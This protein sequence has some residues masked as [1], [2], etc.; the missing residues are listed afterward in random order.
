MLGCTSTTIQKRTQAHV[1]A[2]GLT[3]TTA[4]WGLILCLLQAMGHSAEVIIVP[5]LVTVAN[6]ELP[7]A[8]RLVTALAQSLADQHG[9]N[10]MQAGSQGDASPAHF[11]DV[12]EEY[13][14]ANS[15]WVIPQL[16]QALPEIEGRR[17]LEADAGRLQEQN[18]K[19]RKLEKGFKAANLRMGNVKYALLRFFNMVDKESEFLERTEAAIKVVRENMEDRRALAQLQDI[20]TQAILAANPCVGERAGNIK[21]ISDDVEIGGCKVWASGLN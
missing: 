20:W 4:T 16:E 15:T 14:L 21:V 9:F 8:E 13:V 19:L 6:E 12:T 18:S 5:V 11:N 17:K 1:H 7:L 3:N 10:I 2:S